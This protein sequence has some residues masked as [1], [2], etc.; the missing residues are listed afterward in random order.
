MMNEGVQTRAIS[1][2]DMA[3]LVQED[4]TKRKHSPKVQRSINFSAKLEIVYES[5]L[6]RLLSFHTN[7]V[8]AKIVAFITHRIRAMLTIYF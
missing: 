4:A 1:H 8:W 3:N 2:P 5:Q 6:F 7:N